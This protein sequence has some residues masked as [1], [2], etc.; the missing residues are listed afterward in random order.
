MRTVIK[1]IPKGF[2]VF[3]FEDGK[4]IDRILNQENWYASDHAI[5][6]QPW[7]PNFDPLPLVVYPA[8]VWIQLYNLPIEYWSEII[9]EKIGRTLW[10][11]L[12]VDLDDEDDL[13]KFARLRI[14][15]VFLCL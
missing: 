15:T 1:F 11:L 9:L 4:Y 6:L 10:T 8:L 13:C 7:S 14:V 2:F 5:Y 3:L 12:E